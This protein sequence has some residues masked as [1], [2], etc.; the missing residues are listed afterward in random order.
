MKILGYPLVFR[1]SVQ[2]M[3]W[4]RSSSLNNGTAVVRRQA[5][6]DP[7]WTQYIGIL[8]HHHERYRGGVRLR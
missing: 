7:A 3:R 1:L 2:W 5:R 4:L 8:M 6:S